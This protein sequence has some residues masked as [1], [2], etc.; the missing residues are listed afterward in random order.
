MFLIWIAAGIVLSSMF[1]LE[2]STEGGGL[3]V[4]WGKGTSKTSKKLF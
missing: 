3:T 2:V 1:G 4:S